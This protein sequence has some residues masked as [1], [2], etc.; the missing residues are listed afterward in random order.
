MRVGD[1]ALFN[2]MQLAIQTSQE[3]MMK[4]QLQASSGRAAQTYSDIADQARTA[5]SMEN[6][7]IKIK[8]YQDNIGAQTL[9]LDQMETSVGRM[10]D[11][12]AS[13]KT[14]LTS[15][16]NGTNATQMDLSAQVLPMLQDLQ[17]EVNRQ[18]DGKYLFAGSKTTTAPMNIYAWGN[19][20]P[21][22][23]NM[24]SPAAYTVPTIPATP[25]LFPT[26]V[27]APPD[28]THEYFGY[29]SG[30]TTRQTVRADDNISTAVGAT[31]ADSAIAKFTYALRLAFTAGGAP[32]SEQR[33]RLNGALDLVN[34]VIGN[35]AD[36]RTTIGSQ[37]KMLSDTKTKHENFLGTIEDI[38]NDIQGVDI[39]LT[40]AKL[41]AE[42]TQLQA[43]FL[44][45]SKIN[46]VSLVNYLR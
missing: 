19:P 23:T 43:S 13:L 40:M 18:M 25:T 26:S 8:R 45:I 21:V 28:A 29:Y 22:P 4:Y 41:S 3:R 35:L 15:A 7:F 36:L 30:D 6:T 34:Q 24:N 20:I 39:P 10:Q 11:I 9:R 38:V 2:R 5:V 46:E 1:F 12:A 17:S 37:N 27:V 42:Q 32:Q 44:T 14:L 33:D 16:L 31:G